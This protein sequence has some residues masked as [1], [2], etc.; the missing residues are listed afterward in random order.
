MQT[1]AFK[2]IIPFLI[3][4]S[5]IITACEPALYIT[6][7]NH[8]GGYASMKVTVE[9]PNAFFKMKAAGVKEI[10][11]TSS[12]INAVVEYSYGAGQWDSTTISALV[13]G[14]SKIEFASGNSV[15][16]ITEQEGIRALFEDNIHGKDR[17]GITIKVK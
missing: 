4:L 9:E 14:V 3:A 17:N 12:A 6:F 16:A 15:R 5:T 10:D 13:K 7:E 2:N 1:L 11:F 8:T